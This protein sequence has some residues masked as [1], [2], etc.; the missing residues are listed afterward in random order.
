MESGLFNGTFSLRSLLIDSLRTFILS[1]IPVF[2]SI[3]ESVN[4]ISSALD[5]DPRSS[6]ITADLVPDSVQMSAATTTPLETSTAPLVQ[7]FDYHPDMFMEEAKPENVIINNNDPP[8]PIVR[9]FSHDHSYVNN[10]NE[11]YQIL[12]DFLTFGQ[13]VGVVADSDDEELNALVNTLDVGQLTEIG[14]LVPSRSYMDTYSD[15]NTMLSHD[16]E[17]MDAQQHDQPADL[18]DLIPEESQYDEATSS[19]F[20]YASSPEPSPFCAPSTT[21]KP[22]GVRKSHAKGQLVKDDKYWERRKKNNVASARSRQTRKE[23]AA[24]TELERHRLETINRQLK[25]EI[26][27]L[28]SQVDEH[29]RKFFS[30]FKK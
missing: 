2:S 21:P 30:V 9:S 6:T 19:Q 28:T 26:A 20:S 27:R 4:L 25:E 22:K 14:Q 15:L 24:E 7:S 10:E 18:V 17:P 29:K 1:D 3:T 12:R 16:P 8:M 5:I 13:Q 11:D 23:R